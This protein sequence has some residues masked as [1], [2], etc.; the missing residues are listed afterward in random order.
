QASA[1]QPVTITTNVVNTGDEGGNLNIVLKING[2][3]E[4]SRMVSVGPHTSQPVKFTVT[5]AK[6]GTYDV[7]ILGNTGSFTILG[8]SSTGAA[9]QK[10]GAMIALALMGILIVATVVVL[11]ARR[12]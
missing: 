6:P 4:Q 10:T 1:N 2:L 9:G 11:L 12:S 3:V 8:D 5:R 7:D